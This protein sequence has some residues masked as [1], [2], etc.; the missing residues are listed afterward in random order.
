MD[1]MSTNFG[2]DSSSRFLFRARTNIQTDRQTR[3]NSL[4]HTGGYTA[5]V[6]N[7]NFDGRLHRRH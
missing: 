7:K 2:A 5:G 4:P 3:L 6:G 1:Y